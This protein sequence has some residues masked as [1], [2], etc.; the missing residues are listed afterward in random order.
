[1]SLARTDRPMPLLLQV[2]AML[3]E[4]MSHGSGALRDID[5]AARSFFKLFNK[6]DADGSGKVHPAKLNPEP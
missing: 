4:A 5:P 3:N 2:S 1:M 6:M